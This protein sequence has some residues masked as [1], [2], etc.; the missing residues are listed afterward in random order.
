MLSISTACFNC[1]KFRLFE[2]RLEALETVSGSRVVHI[3]LNVSR[4]Y[5]NSLHYYANSDAQ[6]ASLLC[7][8]IINTKINK[9][10]QKTG[11]CWLQ[12]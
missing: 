3:M 9:I 7:S 12:V 8:I 6:I 2:A 5:A 1:T 10:P 4:Y 11:L